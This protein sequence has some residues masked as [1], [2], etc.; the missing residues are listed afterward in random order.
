MENLIEH[1][2]LGFP[3]ELVMQSND[4]KDEI[5]VRS[6]AELSHFYLLALLVCNTVNI[7]KREERMVYES[8]SPD[9]LALIHLVKSMDYVLKR[10][11]H[12]TM[13]VSI[14]GENVTVQVVKCFPFTAE[15]KRMSVI[16]SIQNKYY[17][18]SKGVPF[19]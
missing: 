16:V 6:R 12:N 10:R 4:G 5:I 19:L 13:E 8:E 1:G 14:R 3:R 17:L 11:D 7:V 15:R 9:E 2:S 18:F